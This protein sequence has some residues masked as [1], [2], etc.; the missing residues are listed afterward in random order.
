VPDYLEYPTAAAATPLAKSRRGLLIAFGVVALLIAG[1]AVVAVGLSAYTLSRL[2]TI[3]RVPMPPEMIAAL[4]A[5]YLAALFAAAG[6]GWGGVGMIR[7]RRWVQPA[8]QAMASLALALGLFSIELATVEFAIEEG[9]NSDEAGIFAAVI[10][11]MFFI[12]LV[13]PASFLVLFLGEN[14]RRTLEHYDP[15]PVWTD[16]FTR[17]VLVTCVWAFFLGLIAM[18]WAGGRHIHFFGR[19]LTDWRVVAVAMTWAAL[20][21]A[22]A[23]AC[24]ARRPIAWWLALTAC[25]LFPT[26]VLLTEWLGN[27][28]TALAADLKLVDSDSYMELKLAHWRSERINDTILCLIGG[29]TLLT[30]L[31]R[32][33]RAF[34]HPAP[35]AAA[36]PPDASSIAVLAAAPPVDAAPPPRIL[37][38]DD[39]PAD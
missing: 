14:V 34:L 15:Y 39:P 9:A 23:A 31:L 25:A 11:L 10:S 30:Y 21:F 2:A 12:G 4:G 16:R 35:P 33:R 6:I 37:T 3:G 32:T 22:T 29:A 36:A 13:L 17:P 24:A 8:G 1:V 7:C 18:T 28:R 19:Y 38:P 5:G 27:P 26:S 20:L